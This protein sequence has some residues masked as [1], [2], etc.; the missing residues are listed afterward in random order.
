MEASSW[1]GSP[2][3]DAESVVWEAFAPLRRPMARNLAARVRVPFE[4]LWGYSRWL[5]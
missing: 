3:Y 1:Y 2:V 4:S 5:P